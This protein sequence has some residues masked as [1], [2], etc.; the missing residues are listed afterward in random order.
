MEFDIVAYNRERRIRL[1]GE[2]I[3]SNCLHRPGTTGPRG[4]KGLCDLCRAERKRKV[5]DPTVRAATVSFTQ[6]RRSERLNQGLCV[7][8]GEAVTPGPRGSARWCASCRSRQ[9]ALRKDR[10]YRSQAIEIYGGKC[11]ACGEN[12]PRMMEFHHVNFDGRED[13]KS[14][15]H[16]RIPRRIALS[17]V[18]DPRIDILCKTCHVALHVPSTRV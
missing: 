12:N 5:A 1:V 18:R 7:Y 11:S 9:Q 4:G 15:E 17:G 14:G 16:G 6:A 13:R 2:G 3:C 8:C 10:E